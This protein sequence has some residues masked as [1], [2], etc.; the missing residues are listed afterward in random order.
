MPLKTIPS[1][2]QISRLYSCKICSYLS[3]KLAAKRFLPPLA[4]NS[5]LTSKILAWSHNQQHWNTYKCLSS[6]KAEALCSVVPKES[7]WTLSPCPWTTKSS[8]IVNGFTFSK[9]SIKWSITS[10]T[11]TMHEITVKNVLL[12]DIILRCNPLILFEEFPCPREPIYKPLSLSSD[13]KPLSLHSDFESLPC[14][15]ALSLC[16]WNLSFWQHHWLCANNGG[17]SFPNAN[18]GPSRA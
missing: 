7:P 5:R 11:T 13:H 3:F 17:V 6:W 12:T 16:P 9:Q 1:Y 14:P 10:V 2:H 4:K 8:K 15:R 18:C